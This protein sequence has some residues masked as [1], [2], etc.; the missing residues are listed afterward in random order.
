[1]SPS[2]AS[3]PRHIWRDARES[4]YSVTDAEFPKL[5]DEWGNAAVTPPARNG[6]EQSQDDENSAWK[7]KQNLF[8]NTPPARR[9]TDSQL[10]S[11]TKPGPRMV[12]ESMDPDDPDNPAFSAARYY[13]EVIEQYVCPKV[14]CG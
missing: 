12:F 11:A 10:E 2:Q 7:G 5:S 13:A 6:G 1:M 9:P 8:P 14:R 4:A 3:G